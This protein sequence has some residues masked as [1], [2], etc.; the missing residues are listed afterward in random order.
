M[1]E[2][3]SVN[4]ELVVLELGISI[5]T[6]NLEESYYT[7]NTNS[8]CLNVQAMEYRLVW[9]ISQNIV[10]AS[11]LCASLG[12]QGTNQTELPYDYL[13]E[14]AEIKCTERYVSY[15]A[16]VSYVQGTQCINYTPHDLA[17]Q[18]L[19]PRGYG[20]TWNSSVRDSGLDSVLSDER[21]QIE[22]H[23]RYFNAL[24]VILLSGRLSR[25]QLTRAAKF[26]PLTV[27]T[28]IGN[29]PTVRA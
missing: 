11:S 23:L 27:A 18:P 5:Y 12:P 2:F 13:L 29:A 9:P 10:F 21:P 15:A 17:P 7:C 28:R 16:N 3:N 8:A 14:T 22:T 6:S 26:R 25:Q 24:T 1:H 19:I 4:A 20:I